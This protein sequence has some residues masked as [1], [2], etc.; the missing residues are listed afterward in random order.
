MG[1]PRRR[2]TGAKLDTE[3]VQ[4]MLDNREQVEQIQVQ[5]IET[6]LL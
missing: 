5:F 6:S 1:D 4:A 2:L 3:C